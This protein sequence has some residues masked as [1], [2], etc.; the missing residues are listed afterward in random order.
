MLEVQL[1]A[2][3]NKQT[4]IADMHAVRVFPTVKT[5]EYKEVC[6][7]SLRQGNTEV[8]TLFHP[9]GDAMGLIIAMMEYYRDNK[10]FVDYAT[11]KEKLPN[12]MML[13]SKDLGHGRYQICGVVI[14]A[15]S[16]VQAINKYRRKKEMV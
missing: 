16:H 15:E 1:K 6:T 13:N 8:G 9:Y 11:A 7:Y 3:I 4:I 2:N 12:N 10:E 14:Q 5:P